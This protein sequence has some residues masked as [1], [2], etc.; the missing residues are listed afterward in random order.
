MDKITYL[1]YIILQYIFN[2]LNCKL[3][4]YLQWIEFRIHCRLK[5]IFVVVF[6]TL[7]FY[8]HTGMNGVEEK[9]FFDENVHTSFVL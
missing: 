1:F 4:I 8:I 5:K 7:I 2:D 3:F 9:V 6:Q